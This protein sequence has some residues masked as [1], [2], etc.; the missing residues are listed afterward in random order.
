[1][2]TKYRRRATVLVALGSFCLILVF[3][4]GCKPDQSSC[5]PNQLVN[6]ED[7]EFCRK[8]SQVDGEC[9]PM[10]EHGEP[11]RENVYCHDGLVCVDGVCDEPV[12][13]GGRCRTSIVC[14]EGLVCNTNV[15]PGRCASIGAPPSL[16]EQCGD[17]CQDGL[18]CELTVYGDQRSYCVP[19][20]VQCSFVNEACPAGKCQ[21]SPDDPTCLTCQELKPDGT[22][23]QYRFE[24]AGGVCLTDLDEPICA[25]YAGPSG[26]CIGDS[27][28][29]PS[30]SCDYDEGLCVGDALLFECGDERC[31]QGEYCDTTGAAPT[32]REKVGIGD[33]CRSDS[34]CEYSFC[35]EQS[36]GPQPTCEAF[37]GL[38]DTCG[39][40]T[41]CQGGLTCIEASGV[42]TCQPQASEGEPCTRA[43]NCEGGLS[44]NLLA[45][46]PV[47]DLVW[48]EGAECSGDIQCEA[49][50]TCHGGIF[51]RP[52]CHERTEEG[53]SCLDDGDCTAENYCRLGTCTPRRGLGDSCQRDGECVMTT[54]VCE[55]DRCFEDPVVCHSVSSTCQVRG[56]TDEACGSENDC[57]LGYF[58]ATTLES[59]ACREQ[60]REGEPCEEHRE[61]GPVMFCGGGTCS[62][63]SCSGT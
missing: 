62:Y 21:P 55:G 39:K 58:C 40:D 8:D 59:P 6:C 51:D 38:A 29:V 13:E 45:D 19:G 57:R 4:S 23:C 44:C 3:A 26:E 36:D 24:C 27:Q 20:N 48:V 16:G 60:L 37:R 15:S 43:A 42:R 18:E 56:E 61:C 22:P 7:D 33:V 35:F 1:M 30:Q 17:E 14:A 41:D 9:R 49:G 34:E 12:V 2:N 25:S 28:C 5:E 50:L 46:P 63:A 54:E 10:R 52:I 11:C 31:G 32:C 47:C 53:S